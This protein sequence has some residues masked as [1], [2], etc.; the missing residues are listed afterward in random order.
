M[1]WD[2]VKYVYLVGKHRS[3]CNFNSVLSLI[4]VL[5]SVT[6]RNPAA[7]NNTTKSVILY[8]FYPWAMSQQPSAMRKHI[9]DVSIFISFN[10]M[11]KIFQTF[12]I[13]QP[14]KFLSQQRIK[15]FFIECI[16]IMLIWWNTY[17]ER[18]RR[19]VFNGMRTQRINIIKSFKR[20]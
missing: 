4:C 8:L 6:L 3:A 10:N 2:F 16:P 5:G 19:I 7:L 20:K 9:I 17:I 12:G 11:K 15:Q 18:R 14:E 1:N 13:Y